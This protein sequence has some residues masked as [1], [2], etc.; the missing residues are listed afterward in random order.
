MAK[1]TKS[2][3]ELLCDEARKAIDAVHGDTSVSQ[4]T[5]RESLSDL[6]DHIH[7]LI[8]TLDC[9]DE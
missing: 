6:N 7:V 4:E 8:E 9:G 1:K 3:H 5:T 2:V